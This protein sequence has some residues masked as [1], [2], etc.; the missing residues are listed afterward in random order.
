MQDHF[1]GEWQ[2]RDL[3]SGGWSPYISPPHQRAQRDGGAGLLDSLL[4]CGRPKGRTTVGVGNVVRN[5]FTCSRS[6]MQNTSKS[7]EQGVLEA[8]EGSEACRTETR[9]ETGLQVV[10]GLV[11]CHP[12]QV[13]GRAE[14]PGEKS[15]SSLSRVRLFVTPWTEAYEAP[16]SMGFSRQ[17]YWSGVP[18]PSQ[19]IFQT[20][21]S[22][23]D[24][25]HCRQMLYPLSH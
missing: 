19:G 12:E 17:E 18:F 6:A 1:S 24:L 23:P 11:P 3:H 8:S 13:K 2:S 10:K 15:M 4:G 20:Q 22:N 5:C 21:G 7:N 25:L 14:R 9:G 16:P